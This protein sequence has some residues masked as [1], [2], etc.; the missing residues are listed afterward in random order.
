[1][2][3]K[4]STGTRARSSETKDEPMV[5]RVCR[6]PVRIASRIWSDGAGDKAQDQADDHGRE[7]LETEI[8]VEW[9]GV[10]K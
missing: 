10:R 9:L 6:Q 8:G 5:D 2:A 1:M 3:V 4:T 7:D